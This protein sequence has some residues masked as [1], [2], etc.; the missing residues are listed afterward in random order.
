MKE[1]RKVILHTG[2][3]GKKAFNDA[4]RKSIDEFIAKEYPEWTIEKH[5]RRKLSIN[6][7]E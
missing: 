4:L 5:S 3:A 1:E 2:L 6:T 7:K